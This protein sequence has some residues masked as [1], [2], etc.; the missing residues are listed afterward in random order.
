M[1]YSLYFFYRKSIIYQSLNSKKEKKILNAVHNE[2]VRGLQNLFTQ[3]DNFAIHQYN[4]QS[5]INKL[6]FG[7]IYKFS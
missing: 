2:Y 4:A 7:N 3:S 1:F 6:I 5:K